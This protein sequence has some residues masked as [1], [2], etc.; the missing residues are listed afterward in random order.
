MSIILKNA[1]LAL[2]LETAG[3]TY[4]GSRFDWNGLVA[5]A[6]YRGVEL[7][8]QEKP[9]FQR[10]P[11]IFGRGLHNEFGIH[12]PVGYD[13][14][15]VGEWFPK[16]GVGWLR[17]DEKPY[18][19]YTQYSVEP[20]TFTVV[21]QGADRAVFSADSGVRNGYGWR[22]EKTVSLEADGWRIAYRLENIGSKPIATDE[23]V[24]NFLCFAGR[25]VGPAY[26][27]EFPWTLQPGRFS[28]TNNPD[29]ILAPEGRSVRFTGKTGKQF[30][31]GGLSLGVLAADGLAASWT[32]TGLNRV[33]RRLSLTERGSFVP[34]GVHLWGWKRVIS[35]ELF[36]SFT[37][38]PGQCETW[39]RHYS[40]ALA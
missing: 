14:C 28:E 16:I 13:D 24:H 3:E 7:L 12:A 35:P 1:D 23:Y 18:F 40:V 4:T 31:L 19:F 33:G 32:L 21:I 39:E 36:H 9:R 2:R 11:A 5:S 25:R 22:Y 26:S 30:Y 17:R 27:L 10:N 34:T 8:G 29:G 37:L 20:A 15:S 6:K 38:A